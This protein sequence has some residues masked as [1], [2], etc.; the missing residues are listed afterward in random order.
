MIREY[1][2]TQMEVWDRFVC[3]SN[4]GTI[5][6]TQK[7]LSYHPDGRFKWN[8]LLFY[9][10]DKLVGV[11]PGALDGATLRSPSG[12][13]YGG[14]VLRHDTRVEDADEIVKSLVDYCRENSIKEIEITPA[15]SIYNDQHDEVLDY[16]LL[17]NR[18]TTLSY[19]YSSIID[20]NGVRLDKG[21]RSDIHRAEQE[22]VVVRSNKDF[23]ILYPI[24]V[25][26]KKKYD[27][28]PVHNVEE[29]EAIDGMFDTGLFF[30]YKDDIPI[31][32]MWVIP[33]NPRCAL[34]FYS[35]HL[36]EHRKYNGIVCLVAYVIEWA[37]EQGFRYLDYGVSTD[38]TADEDLEWSL[39]RFK[40]RLGGHGCL[41][42]TF[43]R[44]IL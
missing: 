17:H 20:I 19:Q 39:V 13:S 11:M 33:T 24:L 25:E 40:E 34:I 1:D 42:K 36:Y 32:G 12:A 9:K 6:H 2:H 41:R 18:F 15:L 23:N 27:A 3:E 31:A 43:L 30:A 38:T 35:A 5:F 22:A 29:M 14:V 4:N 26:N 7:F 37:K 16:A 21:R 10:D 28:H 8:H 44:K